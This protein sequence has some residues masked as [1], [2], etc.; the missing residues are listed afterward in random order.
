MDRP[1]HVGDT[2]R[3]LR[4]N[5]EGSD[6]K[7]GDTFKVKKV[8]D[9]EAGQIET[10]DVKRLGAGWWFGPSSYE[11]IASAEPSIDDTDSEAAK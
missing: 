11:I 5:A 9:A 4:D 8:R 1:V 6:V 2:I 3:I 7:T 10:E